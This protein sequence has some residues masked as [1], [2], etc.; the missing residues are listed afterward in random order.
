[1]GGR[2]KLRSTF[3]HFM[4]QKKIEADNKRARNESRTINATITSLDTPLVV[5]ASKVS[6]AFELPKTGAEIRELNSTSLCVRSAPVEMTDN[7]QPMV[8]KLS[9]TFSTS[10]SSRR[11]SCMTKSCCT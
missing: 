6:P 2:R 9:S 4:K 8:Y 1:M 5:M 3:A 7:V 11:C 10:L